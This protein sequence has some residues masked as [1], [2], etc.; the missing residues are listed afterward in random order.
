MLENEINPKLIEAL[1]G[2]KIDKIAAGGWH[3]CAISTTG[4]LYTWG[5]NSN[6][7]LGLPNHED[8]SV[9]ATPQPVCF[10]DSDCN[11][12][13]VACGSKHTVILIGT[14]NITSFKNVILL[15]YA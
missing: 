3:S 12:K 4:D 2:I 13:Y 14:Y 11:V 15:T 8:I 5:W 10:D 7:Q 6:G 1:A 9:F